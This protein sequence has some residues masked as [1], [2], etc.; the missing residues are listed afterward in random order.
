MLFLGVVFILLLGIMAIFPKEGL[1]INDQLTLY[2]P[3][4]ADFVADDTTEVDMNAILAEVDELGKIDTTPKPTPDT[5]IVE[6]DDPVYGDNDPRKIQYPEGDLSILY[7]AF[8]ALEAAGAEAAPAH[9][10]HFGDSQIEGDRMTNLIRAR[11]QD[12]FGGGGPGLHAAVPAITSFSLRQKHSD[13][14]VRYPGYGRKKEGVNHNRYGATA[15]FARFTPIVPDSMLDSVEVSTGWLQI[16]KAPPAYNKAKSFNQMRLFY[17]YNRRKVVLKLFVD[18]EEISVDTIPPNSSLQTRTWNFDG[19]PGKIMVFMEGQDSPE[20]YGVVLQEQNGVVVNNIG[21]R[22]QSGTLFSGLERGTFTGMLLGLNTKLIIMQFGGNTVPYIK[23]EKSAKN[24]GNSVR[25]Q[26]RF[27]KRILPDVPVILIGPSDM[28][29]KVQGKL[30][31]YPY[32]EDVRNALREGAFEAGAAYFDIYE[33]MGGRN[34]MIGWVEN[35][36]PL[37]ASDYVHFNPKGAR[38]IS[39][40]F[41]A[42]FMED[43]AAYRAQE[44][45]KKPSASNGAAKKDPKKEKDDV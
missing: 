32:L 18:D 14:F 1:K 36:P 25:N 44:G 16:E 11:F 10:F 35:D 38:K 2:F 20:V 40:A 23:G 22:G 27:F 9:V 29:T 30:Q 39:Q 43:Y 41:V 28:S 17:G 21:L 42:S 34:S 8:R 15:S 37:A 19:T 26:I 7:P 12:K 45:K 6:S 5:V 24:Y 4:L 31:T 33:V 13:N 3:T